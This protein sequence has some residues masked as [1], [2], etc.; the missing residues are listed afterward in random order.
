MIIFDNTVFM[1]FS[2]GNLLLMF[3]SLKE[4]STMFV[5][6]GENLRAVL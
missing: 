1:Y 2:T 4:G 5:S 6:F 3:A